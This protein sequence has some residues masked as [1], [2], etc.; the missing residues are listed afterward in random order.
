MTARLIDRRSPCV[1]YMR[2]LYLLT[3]AAALGM[4]SG[5]SSSPFWASSLPGA[6]AAAAAAGMLI[7]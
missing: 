6:S 1:F 5:V 2:F 4:S 7:D 3:S